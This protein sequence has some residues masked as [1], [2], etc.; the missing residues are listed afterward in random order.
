MMESCY[1]KERSMMA[2]LFSPI[3]GRRNFRVETRWNKGF[4]VAV[5]SQTEPR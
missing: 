5:D 4:R 2:I 3:K 1:G